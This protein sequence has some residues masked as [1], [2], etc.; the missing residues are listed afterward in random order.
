MSFTFFLSHGA[1]PLLI[2][3]R[4]FVNALRALAEELV[5]LQPDLI[6]M[7]SPHWMA[8]HQFLVN[9]APQPKCIQDYYGFPAEFYEYRY[10]APNDPAFAEQIV[11]AGQRR[12][13]PVRGTKEWGLD[14]GAWVPLYLMFP[15]RKIPV[16]PI[17]SATLT[18][19]AHYQWGEAIRETAAVSGK[20]VLFIGTGST[21]HRLDLVRFSYAGSEL[22]PPGRA[23]DELLFKLLSEGK[24]EEVL[25]LAKSEPVLFQQAAPEGDLRTLYLTLGA[26]GRNAH[27]E[28]LCY[29]PWYYAASLVAIRFQLPPI[30]V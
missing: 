24:H 26:A 22:Y 20:K 6:V 17:S 25:H 18:P 12:G 7:A 4:L 29:E 13:L 9:I 3:D 14:H 28:I 11:I 21:I 27:G 23:F 2:E 15:E 16:L 5:R 30:E 10:D 8:D 1:P 19:T